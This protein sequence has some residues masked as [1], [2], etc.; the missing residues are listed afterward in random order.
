M[1]TS[2][3][4][5]IDK[6]I[7]AVTDERSFIKTFSLIKGNNELGEA[8]GE[9]VGSG[10]ATV[11]GVQ[12]AIFAIDA[13]VL[14]GAIGARNAAKLAK[15][16]GDAVKT[17]SPIVGI[18]DSE[19]ARFAEGVEAMA[20]YDAVLTALYAARERIP[21][22]L[23]VKGKCFGMLGLAL[24]AADCVIAYE[25]AVIASSSPLI[26]AAKAG[27]DVKEIGTAALHT[28]SGLIDLTVKN[29][30][31]LKEKLLKIVELFD[32]CRIKC[33]DD[34][35]RVAKKLKN[36]CQVKDI[37]EEAFDKD[38][39]LALKTAF[40]PEV[41]TGLARLNGNAVGVVAFGEKFSGLTGAAAVKISSLL[42]LCAR[43]TFPVVTLI[44]CKGIEA[45]VQDEYD[46]LYEAAA[47]LI[48]DY[49]RQ[50]L[51][52]IALIY[53][54]AVGVGYTVFAGRGAA[55]HVLAWDGAYIGMLD[56]EAT[57]T[58]LYADRISAAKDRD[59][60]L[61]K[62]AKAYADESASATVTA[63]S[64]F[65]DNVIAPPL[66]RQYLIAAVETYMFK[67]E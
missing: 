50:K 27:K 53:G 61:K 13:T 59:K 18:I 12:I 26:L 34:P 32:S 38:S 3:G 46:C 11:G 33:E 47:R 31:E 4:V 65:I 48:G 36:G 21:V 64:G 55:D 60:A 66:T 20:G 30:A 14:G 49:R 29:D 41:V 17:G 52:R 15:L 19:G 8:C 6:L 45:D 39:F 40:V 57:A 25:D 62:L 56:G 35:N 7:A 44:N 5:S 58:L 24:K 54:K 1:A 67:E 63:E 16:I 42:E 37:L 22:I 23:A 51:T 10:F 43:L 9:G 2:T 28:R